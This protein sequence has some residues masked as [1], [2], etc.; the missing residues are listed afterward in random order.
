MAAKSASR[1][2]TFGYHKVEALA[3]FMNGSALILITLFIMVEAVRRL[4]HPEAVTGIAMMA[5]A[6]L[7][8]LGNLGVAMILRKSAGQ[9]I[10][11]KTAYL[12][13]LGDAAISLSPVVG[14]IL[15]TMMG[16]T[17]S[18]STISL[19]IG[20]GVFLGTWTVLRESVWVLLDRVP[21]GIETE[22]VAEA[23]LLV[24]G[25]RNVHDLHVW[26]V[27]SKLRLLTCQLLVDD[28][29]ISESQGLQRTIRSMLFKK[30]GIGHS[31]VQLETSS[32]HSQVLYCNLA[33]RHLHQSKLSVDLFS[34]ST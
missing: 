34:S 7:A 31:T 10:N 22:K 15:I 18:D 24:P 25:V 17:R 13:N 11:I 8:S 1:I 9:N 30:F 23:L 6:L 19:L 27:D 21:D 16:L 4:F 3:A 12:H 33:R 14:G 32:C 29:W 2:G 26:S 5:V 20:L 28:T